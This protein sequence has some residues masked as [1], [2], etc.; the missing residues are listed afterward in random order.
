MTQGFWGK[1]GKM[2]SMM[3]TMCNTMRCAMP[4]IK[5]DRTLLLL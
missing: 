5:Q 1:A 3:C 4:K 2:N